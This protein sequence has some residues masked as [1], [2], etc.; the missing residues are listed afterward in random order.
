MG[1]TDLVSVV[2]MKNLEYNGAKQMGTESLGNMECGFQV[3][4]VEKWKIK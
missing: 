4:S 1:R 2:R 3:M